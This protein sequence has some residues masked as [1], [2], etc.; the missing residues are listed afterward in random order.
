MIPRDAFSLPA[1]SSF[2][3]LWLPG[4]N[5]VC[6]QFRG[7]AAALNAPVRQRCDSSWAGALA[8]LEPVRSMILG[9]RTPEPKGRRAGPA[10]CRS[11]G[12][13]RV[14]AAAGEWPPNAAGRPPRRPP[15][16]GDLFA[17]L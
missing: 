4:E 13:E 12:R 8:R 17:C 9:L 15:Y 7:G 3:L 14:I 11:P 5:A 10:Q 6:L 2:L 1:G 16:L